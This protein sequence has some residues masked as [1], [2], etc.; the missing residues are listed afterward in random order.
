VEGKGVWIEE[1]EAELAR[2]GLSFDGKTGVPMDVPGF[3]MDDAIKELEK[4][5]E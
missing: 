1:L 5:F 2:R 4:F 3:R